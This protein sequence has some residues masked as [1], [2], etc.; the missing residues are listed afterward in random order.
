MGSQS[1]NWLGPALSEKMRKAQMIGVNATMAACVRH[2]KAN[3]P[4]QNQTGILEGSIDIA[5][6]AR[7]DGA[8]VAG[9]WGSRDVKYAL[10]HELG[11]VIR[12][13]RAKALRFQLPD[14]SWR[15]ATEVTIPARPYLRPAADAI[16]PQ[17]AA[18]IRKAFESAGGAA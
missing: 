6:F 16:Y 8:G 2:A 14:G 9:R 5:D 17:L 15:M 11:G 4:W 7:E 3:H 12:P 10:I 13:V 1:L 18:N